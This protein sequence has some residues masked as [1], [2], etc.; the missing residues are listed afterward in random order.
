MLDRSNDSESLFALEPRFGVHAEK[1]S[2]F[3]KYS[4]VKVAPEQTPNTMIKRKKRKLGQN[5]GQG[6]G[7]FLAL[8]I[9]GAVLVVGAV[10]A[11]LVFKKDPKPPSQQAQASDENK[12]SESE[13]NGS[14]LPE[15]TSVVLTNSVETPETSPSIN[16]DLPLGKKEVWT[17]G[18]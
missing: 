16:P 18:G 13:D 6:K 9:G 11:L 17:Y 5:E 2:Y 1:I 7:V 8:G 4:I 3:N 10:L 15:N 14:L 12:T